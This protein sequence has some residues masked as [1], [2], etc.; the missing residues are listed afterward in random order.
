MVNDVASTTE[1]TIQICSLNV[2]GLALRYS[3][4]KEPRNFFR[5]IFEEKKSL[6]PI[7]PEQ[8]HFLRFDSELKQAR[9]LL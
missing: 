5:I 8:T 7:R 3:E 9:I 6:F 2:L 1:T 4:I